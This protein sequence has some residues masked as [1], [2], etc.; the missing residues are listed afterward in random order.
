MIF[1]NSRFSPFLTD[2]SC[3][4]ELEGLNNERLM[5]VNTQWASIIIKSL[6]IIRQQVFTSLNSQGRFARSEAFLLVSSF[7]AE[8]RF[9]IKSRC[10]SVGRAVDL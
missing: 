6:M 8:R 4:F 3:R 5:E 9:G 7:A 2:D 10:S 1:E